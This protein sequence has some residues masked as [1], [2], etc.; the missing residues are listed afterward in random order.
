MTRSRPFAHAPPLRRSLHWLPIQ[1]IID[2][3]IRLLTF[4]TLQPEQPSYLYNLLSRATPSRTLRSNQGPLLAVPK[5]KTVTG[6]RAFSSCAP[7][8]W[9][10]LPL[11]M[12]SFDSIYVFRKHLKT[13]LLDLPIHHKLLVTRLPDDEQETPM[14][15]GN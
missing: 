3:K 2:F 15:Y 10:C 11:S 4:K 8:L 9:N 13:Y 1:F 5:V 12:R 14:I 7:A 6:S